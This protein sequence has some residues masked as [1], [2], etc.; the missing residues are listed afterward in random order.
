MKTNLKTVSP[1][2]ILTDLGFSMSCRFVP[3]SQVSNGITDEGLHWQ[4]IISCNEL[5]LET[6]YYQ[7]VGHIPKYSHFDR[8]ESAAKKVERTCESGFSNG[9]RIPSPSLADV[10]YSVTMDA[11]AIDHQDFA[12]WAADYGYD[13]DSRMEE[14]IYQSCITTGLKLRLMVGDTGINRMRE[15]F[16]D[17]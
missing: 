5:T 6:P 16:Q 9:K 13:P 11:D 15:A 10:M 3:Q 8:T 14:R 4:C 2:E 7:G 17:Y 12:S 1:S